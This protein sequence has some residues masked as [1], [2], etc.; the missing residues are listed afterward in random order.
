[1]SEE[2]QMYMAPEFSPVP[3]S[4]M[5][6]EA[7][8]AE[9]AAI[10][11]PPPSSKNRTEKSQRF[12]KSGPGRPTKAELRA[13]TSAEYR[14][15]IISKSRRLHNDSASRSRARFSAMLDELWNEIPITERRTTDQLEVFG[16]RQISRAE[17]VE[18]AILYVRKLQQHLGQ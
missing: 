11:F 9:D 14:V 6:E 5:P 8:E 15:S 1:M 2:A 12:S 17:K 13:R 18:L 10:P 4:R 16:Q 3:S 7:P